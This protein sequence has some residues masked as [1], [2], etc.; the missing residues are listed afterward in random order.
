MNDVQSIILQKNNYCKNTFE[1]NVLS[2]PTTN[3]T[4]TNH[5]IAASDNLDLTQCEVVVGGR[6]SSSPNIS[7]VETICEKYETH[8]QKCL[9]CPLDIMRNV[10]TLMKT[11]KRTRKIICRRIIISSVTLE[12]LFSVKVQYTR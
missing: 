2:L 12:G 10:V 1:L 11:K 5:N 3:T 8:V 4:T 9:N 6:C 7:N